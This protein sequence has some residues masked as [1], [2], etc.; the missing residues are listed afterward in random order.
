M[1]DFLKRHV[2]IKVRD[3]TRKLT[4]YPSAFMLPQ[5]QGI[6]WL[7]L[8][9]ALQLPDAQSLLLSSSDLSRVKVTRKDPATGKTTEFVVDVPK[10]RYTPQDLFLRDGDVIEVPEK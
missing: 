6:Y 8:D 5:W 4:L 7:Y 10:V 2:R 3:Q 9:Y 1:I